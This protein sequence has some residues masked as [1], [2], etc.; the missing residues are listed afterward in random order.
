[1]HHH[2]QLLGFP[3]VNIGKCKR[4]R[5]LKEEIIKKETEHENLE[6]LHSVHIGKLNETCLEE[7]KDV[8]KQLFDKN[9]G[10]DYP[11]PGKPGP[12][13]QVNLRITVEMF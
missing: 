1:M 12:I 11:P 3:W 13:V 5:W 9:I 7:N 2:T 6:N 8:T 4:K 10:K